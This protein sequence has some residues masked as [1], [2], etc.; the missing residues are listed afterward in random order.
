MDTK[1]SA[2]HVV[3]LLLLLVSSVFIWYGKEVDMM[4]TVFLTVVIYYF[5]RLYTGI[6][7]KQK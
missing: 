5:N 1:S 4:K 3:A 2:V 6:N 7:N